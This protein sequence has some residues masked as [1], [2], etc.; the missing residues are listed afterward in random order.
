MAE[1]KDTPQAEGKTTAG[2]RPRQE[3]S[4]QAEYASYNPDGSQL[5][6]HDY[7]GIEEH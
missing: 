6:F 2:G 4:T 7:K 5:A 3:L 1:Q